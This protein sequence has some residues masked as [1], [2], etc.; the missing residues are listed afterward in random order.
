MASADVV[1]NETNFPD[2]NFRAY[3][4][5]QPYGEDGIITDDEI[6]EITFM[7][8][9]CLEIS[10]LKGIE[11]FTSLTFLYCGLNKLT[12][13]DM[14][15]NVALTNLVCGENQLTTLDVSNNEVLTFLS[16]GGNLLTS[17]DLSKNTA[18]REL[19]CY[20]NQLTSLDLSKNTALTYIA[21]DENQLTSL[22]LSQN[23]ELNTLYCCSNSI[24]GS[25]MDNLIA[26]LPI[27]NRGWFVVINTDDEKE[28]NVCTTIQVQQAKAKGWVVAC[29][30]RTG[31]YEYEGSDP[32]AVEQIAI[33]KEGINDVYTLGGQRMN[34]AYR[35]INILKMKDGTTRKVVF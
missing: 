12:S 24:S 28:K 2:A 18:L 7:Q 1:I 10:S 32:A 9:E 8:V 13:L 20:A 23:T 29:M 5:S 16:C 26:S 14:S 19:A 25:N 27:Q 11:F 4:L 17:L 31:S 33:D 6:S 30:T 15:K 34:N 35:G 21:C 3:L 22:D